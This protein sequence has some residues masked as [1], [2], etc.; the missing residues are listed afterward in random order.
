M[1]VSLEKVLANLTIFLFA[2]H[3]R[4]WLKKYANQGIIGVQ[5]LMGNSLK[6]V[7]V[8]AVALVRV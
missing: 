5:T 4:M 6:T 1:D 3:L 7:W 8:A 2:K